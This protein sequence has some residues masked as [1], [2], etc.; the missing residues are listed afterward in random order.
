MCQ[1]VREALG[2]RTLRWADASKSGR[3][4][5][6]DMLRNGRSVTV[7]TGTSAVIEEDRCWTL[8]Q[9]AKRTGISGSIVLQILREGLK[10][11]KTAAKWGTDYLN[12]EQQLWTHYEAF[13]IIW[14][15]A[16]RLKRSNCDRVY[17]PELKRQTSEWCLPQS[18]RKCKVQQHVTQD[19]KKM[20]VVTLRSCDR[21]SVRYE[22]TNPKTRTNYLPDEF[23]RNED[24]GQEKEA[25]VSKVSKMPRT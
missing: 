22:R 19:Q 25:V 20:C 3:V 17:E 2:D 14:R 24:L 23:K 13:R 1:E 10:I 9:V 11:R 6:S 5:T 15:R 18:P 16:Q 8:K 4:S 12:Q 7:H 21:I